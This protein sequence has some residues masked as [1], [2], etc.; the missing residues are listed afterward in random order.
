MRTYWWTR[1]ACALTLVGAM[2]LSAP[3]WVAADVNPGDTVTKDNMA[4]AGDLLI[5]GIQWFVENG[6]PIQVGEYKKVNLPKLYAE[7]TEKYSGQV[8]LSAD[9][10][11]MFNYVAGVPFPNIDPN[12]PMAGQRSCGTR[13]RNRPMLTMSGRNGSSNLS[14]PEAK[15]SVCTAPSSGAG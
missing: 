13:S 14:M 11:E 3:S 1:I 8:Q 10:R 2:G 9:G 4:E 12:D 5:P 15:W 7:A 6:M